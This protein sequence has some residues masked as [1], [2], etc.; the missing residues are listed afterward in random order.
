MNKAHP[1]LKLSKLIMQVAAWD[2]NIITAHRRM[3]NSSVNL[4]SFSDGV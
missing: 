4:E 1:G 2:A 3:G